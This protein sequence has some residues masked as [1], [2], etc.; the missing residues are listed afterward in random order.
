[1]FLDRNKKVLK[2]AMMTRICTKNDIAAVLR[3]QTKDTPDVLV[4][5]QCSQP[6]DFSPKFGWDF[7]APESARQFHVEIAEEWAL[8]TFSI[9][10]DVLVFDMPAHGEATRLLGRAVAQVITAVSNA[11][12]AQKFEIKSGRAEDDLSALVMAERQK[13]LGH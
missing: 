5:E 10:G 8:I 12:Q 3:D 6:K 2:L 4:V 9:A 11:S 13:L 7:M 1:M